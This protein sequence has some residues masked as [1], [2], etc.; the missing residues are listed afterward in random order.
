M[1]IKVKKGRVPRSC[2]SGF[3]SRYTVVRGDTMYLI[4]QRYGI[5]LMALINANL[6]ITNPNLIY[7]GDVLCVPSQLVLPCCVIL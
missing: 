4:A 2:P 5:P 1:L 3:Q 7:P 6:H